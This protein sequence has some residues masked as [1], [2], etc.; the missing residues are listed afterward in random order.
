MS[1]TMFHKLADYIKRR[2]DEVIHLMQ[3]LIPFRSLGPLNG[4][5]GEAR[6]GEWILN[7]LRNL[8]IKDVHNY[9]APDDSVPGG[10]RPNIVATIPGKDQSKNIW[11]MSHIDVV[12]EGD[13]DKWDTNPFE[14][15]V[16]DGRIYGRGTE[17][18]HQGVVSSLIV[19]GAFSKLNIQPRYNLKLVYVSDEETNSI[20]G[21]E[22][23]M[24]YHRDMFG[25]EDIYIVPDAG[26][27]DG[28]MIE[29]AEKS[30]LWLKFT[31][32]GKQVHASTPERGINAFKAAAHLIVKLNTLYETFNEKDALFDPPI[33][34]FEPTRRE[35]NVPNVNTIPGD[36]VFYLDCRILPG[37]T[38]DEVEKR[39]GELMAE[40]ENKFGVEIIME[41][42][43]REDAAPSTA[44]D[45]P[46]VKALQRAL[47]DTRN[48]E[49]QPVGIG[50]GTV[51]AVFRR[52]GLATAVWATLD[53]MAHQPNEYCRIDN[54]LKDALVFAHVA[55][56]KLD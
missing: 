8:G 12:P 50:G 48:I 13:L 11:I 9:P 42:V 51:A 31:T 27:P 43:Q 56:H 34:T 41:E 38:I 14:A 20:Y 52:A 32:K 26:E 54:V 7:Y 29:I 5:E 47:R 30:I 19:A 23:L 17:D 3:N 40:T 36:D 15:V 45:A 49:G 55:T 10:Q 25:K 24:E 46:V 39:I 1:D 35:A 16:R 18:N 37:Y 6:E 53:D 44:A 33:S 21:L 4:G 28:T 2:E 22:Y